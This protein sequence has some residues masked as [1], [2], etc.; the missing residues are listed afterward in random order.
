M[1]PLDAIADGIRVFPLGHWPVPQPL[2]PAVRVLL[3]AVHA[4]PALSGFFPFPCPKPAD[5]SGRTAVRERVVKKMR[6]NGSTTT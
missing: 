3:R 4:F 1:L 5:S 6:R 2:L